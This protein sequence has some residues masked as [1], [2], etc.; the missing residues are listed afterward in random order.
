MHPRQ[1]MKPFR[2]FAALNQPLNPQPSAADAKRLWKRFAHKSWWYC[3][4][5][6]AS[7]PPARGC[8][9]QHPVAGA[10]Q[11]QLRDRARAF[12][13]YVNGL[14]HKARL[15]HLT[16][17][18]T[19]QCFTDSARLAGC[20][21]AALGWRRF[22]QGVRTWAD[23]AA[24]REGVHEPGS[25]AWE[26]RFGIR[27]FGRWNAWL[28]PDLCGSVSL[29]TWHLEQKNYGTKIPLLHLLS[30]LPPCRCLFRGFC[31][32]QQ[33]CRGKEEMREFLRRAVV[34]AL[35][36]CYCVE[37]VVPYPPTFAT[38]QLVDSI[39]GLSL[40]DFEAWSDT[41]PH[42]VFYSL[43]L[44]AVLYVQANAPLREQ[45]L[46]LYTDYVQYEAD[47]VR[48][49][50]TIRLALPQS[51]EVLVRVDRGLPREVGGAPYVH[52]IL[53]NDFAN[54]VL[55]MAAARGVRV[56]RAVREE[57]APN[58]SK[59]C[60]R[61]AIA[62]ATAE[63]LWLCGLPVGAA[64]EIRA[65]A[66]NYATGACSGST[67][68]RMCATLPAAT[69]AQLALVMRGFERAATLLALPLAHD[70]ATQQITALRARTGTPIGAPNLPATAGVVYYC[71]HCDDM[72]CFIAQDNP[73]NIYAV[74]A[75]R[76]FTN[77]Q[78]FSRLHCNTKLEGDCGH[79]AC[80]GAELIRIDLKGVAVR[81]RG[82][83]LMLCPLCACVCTFD[84]SRCNSDG[85]L[86]CGCC[87]DTVA[88]STNTDPVCVFCDQPATS[89][90]QQLV[91]F[92]TSS[93]EKSCTV[94]LCAKHRVCP[95]RAK[96]AMTRDR[97][98]EVVARQNI[99]R[100]CK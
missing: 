95:M 24:E 86:S 77:Q 21:D 52:K 43:K 28:L 18:A 32:S 66:M 51:S 25:D 71:A 58:I 16:S 94:V 42:I 50:D 37:G 91:V 34:T 14:Q 80:G 40:D 96:S 92:E 12:A 84:L 1:T 44:I 9:L 49:S 69:L 4:A 73:L 81:W 65:H 10:R 11:Q 22:F 72:K 83:W 31:E 57:W 56:P 39:G 46:A 48:I 98:L 29:I 55:N 75:P 70:V 100:A 67:V 89:K 15:S 61:L 59:V 60:S 90:R 2:A 13:A 8:L 38:M 3:P 7:C 76:V 99:T 64:V 78:D 47:V 26:E 74:G 63:S 82:R 19:D 23:T 53:K 45:L 41:I 87:T 93:R 6:G 36:G 17:S 85:V 54:I 35:M 5:C 20:L 68:K 62:D 88:S 79:A 33:R 30:K 27:P 97:L